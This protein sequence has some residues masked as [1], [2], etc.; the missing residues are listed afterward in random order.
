MCL[1]QVS[2]PAFPGHTSLSRWPVQTLGCLFPLPMCPAWGPTP[3]CPLPGL[4]L[5][6]RCRPQEE[7]AGRGSEG[8]AASLPGLDLRTLAPGWPSLPSALDRG[9]TSSLG[10]C[11]PIHT[12]LLS[13]QNR[14]ASSPCGSTGCPT[15]SPHTQYQHPNAAA[16]CEPRVAGGRGFVWLP[17]ASRWPRES[18]CFNRSLQEQGGPAGGD[19]SCTWTWHVDAARRPENQHVSQIATEPPQSS[20]VAVRVRDT[21]APEL[22]VCPL[23]PS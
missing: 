18:I 17:E 13:Q 2:L 19:T 8:A 16:P 3:L 20:R 21:L 7:S 6:E 14:G 23:L 10:P 4:S 11:G 12:S 9:P 1:L 22:S 15:A 5:H